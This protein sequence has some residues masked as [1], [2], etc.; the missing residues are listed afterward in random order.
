MNMK[1][2][3]IRL[4]ELAGDR[5]HKITYSLSDSGRGDASQKCTVYVDGFG[6]CESGFW[7]GALIEIESAMSGNPR[8]TED[9]PTCARK[10]D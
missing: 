2:A 10:I 4:M 5:Y 6:S 8:I 3:K 1:E 7:E 9:L